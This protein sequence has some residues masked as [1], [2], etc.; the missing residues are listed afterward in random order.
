MKK[1]TPLKAEHC[2]C[3]ATDGIGLPALF[4]EPVTKS[5]TAIVYLHG[6]GSGNVFSP[7]QKIQDYAAEFIH[8]NISFFAFNN[9]GAQYLQKIKRYGEPDMDGNRHV[10]E[11]LK[12][13]TAY[14]LIEECIYDINGVVTFLKSRGYSRFVLMGESTGANKAVLYQY[15]EKNPSVIGLVLIGGGDDS[16]IYYRELG[17]DLFFRL[18]DLAKEKIASGK[19]SDFVPQKYLPFL[20]SWQSFCNTVNPD[21]DY[22]I[23]PFE[24]YF[25]DLNLGKKPLFKEYKALTL[26]ILVLYGEEDEFCFG[27]VPEILTLLRSKTKNKTNSSFVS[28][29]QSDHGLTGK[30]DIAATHISRWL[31]KLTKEE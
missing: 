4:F 16:G 19:G 24:D 2:L 17:R 8:K 1:S 29:P 9:R 21:G 5:T 15:K 28:L 23:F 14:E 30:T 3:Y 22:N 25:E 11:E 10:V 13:G 6:N 26:P 7:V 27:R 31:E 20:L 12:G 18:L